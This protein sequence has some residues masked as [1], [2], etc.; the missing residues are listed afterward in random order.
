MGVTTHVDFLVQEGQIKAEA[1]VRHVRRTSGMG[2][3]F[4]AVAQTDRPHLAALLIRLR[5]V[6]SGGHQGAFHGDRCWEIT[7]SVETSASPA[8]AWHYWTDIANWDDTRA[9]FDGNYTIR[10]RRVGAPRQTRKKFS[11]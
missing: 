11:L 3:K 9:E 6:R 2:M 5:R 7:D 8:F 1:I 4:T 10:F